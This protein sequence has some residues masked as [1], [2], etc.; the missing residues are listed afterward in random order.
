VAP[1]V[2]AIAATHDQLA[3]FEI[4]E[5]PDNVAGV[6]TQGLREP[7]LTLRPVFTKQP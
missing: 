2:R 7:M 4:V 3:I 5:Q 1:P 6:Q